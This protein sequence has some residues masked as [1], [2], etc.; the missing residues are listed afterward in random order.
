MANYSELSKAGSQVNASQLDT[1]EVQR[2]DIDDPT[3]LA[4]L[5]DEG[6]VVTI[7]PPFFCCCS[8]VLT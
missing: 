5:K 1:S 3:W 2:F 7:L 4:H 6:Y 8:S